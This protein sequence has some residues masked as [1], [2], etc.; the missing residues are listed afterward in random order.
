MT[1]QVAST[2]QAHGVAL[3]PTAAASNVPNFP[4]LDS[5][6]TKASAHCAVISL[7]K[8]KADGLK[9]AA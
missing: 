8:P 5:L 7:D 6:K 1:S 3:V 9:Q 4:G 2:Q